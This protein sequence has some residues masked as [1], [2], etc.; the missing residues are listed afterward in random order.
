[1][2]RADGPYQMVGALGDGILFD[3]PREAVTGAVEEV[4]ARYLPDVPVPY[5]NTRHANAS[6]LLWTFGYSGQRRAL[7]DSIRAGTKFEIHLWHYEG[8]CDP[9]AGGPAPGARRKEVVVL[10]EQLHTEWDQQFYQALLR[11]LLRE[12]LQAVFTQAPSE[13][14]FEGRRASGSAHSAEGAPSGAE[15]HGR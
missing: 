8:D 14:A 3:C 11:N 1:M 4:V 15:S 6:R 9:P 7:S 2:D 10:S 12:T 5:F 13:Q